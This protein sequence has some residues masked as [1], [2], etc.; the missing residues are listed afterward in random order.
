MRSLQP[1]TLLMGLAAFAAGSGA[2]GHAQEFTIA[3]VASPAGL[4][5]EQLKPKT[6]ALF[7]SRI[8]RRRERSKSNS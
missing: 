4:G 2:P 6:T 1:I 7:G 8:G 5:V 3:E